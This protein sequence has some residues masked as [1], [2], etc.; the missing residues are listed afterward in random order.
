MEFNIL[1]GYNDLKI[2][3]IL[4]YYKLIHHCNAKNIKLINR[5]SFA[6]YCKGAF[7]CQWQKT[8]DF[9]LVTQQK[10]KLKK[11]GII[12]FTSHVYHFLLKCYVFRNYLKY[13]IDDAAQC[14]I[15]FSYRDLIILTNVIYINFI[16]PKTRYCSYL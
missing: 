15:L 6:V 8:I 1:F 16:V 9:F 10:L 13:D 12:L 7:R 11:K 14:N 5:A 3:K 4:A 2:L